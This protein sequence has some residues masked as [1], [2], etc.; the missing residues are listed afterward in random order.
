MTDSRKPLRA[1]LYLRL[2]VT[3]DE[4]TSI[5]R[6]EK[7]LRDLAD[8]EGWEVVQV[9]T[10]D[11][12]SGGK[13]RAK[14]DRALEMLRDGHADVIAVWKFDRWS[15]QGVRAVAD[16]VETIDGREASGRPALFVAMGDGIRSDAQTWRMHV[17]LIAEVGRMERENV[18]TRVA[19]ARAHL[20]QQRKHSGRVPYGYRTCPH[21]SGQGRG[22]EIDPHESK[23]VRRAVDMVLAGHSPYLTAK[24]LNEEGLTPRT[25]PL[26]NASLLADMLRRDSLL[27][28]MT[29]RIR[30]D[31]TRTYRPL[32]DENGLPEQ[33]WPP[34]I[35]PDEAR[36]LRAGISANSKWGV[37]TRAGIK[38]G[39][40]LLSG[41][42]V[43]ATCG[44]SMRA[45]QGD[46]LA[47][48]SVTNRYVCGAAPGAC[49][50]K[51]S[52]TAH[53]IEDHVV[54]EF[55]ALAGHFQVIEY[56]E[57]SRDTGELAEV[58]HAITETAAQMTAP[59]ANI[60]AL[61]DRLTK[62]RARRE[63]LE[64]VP[65]EPVVEQVE[66]GQTFA[67]AWEAR[68]LPGRRALLAGALTGS[69]V[70]K[71]AIRGSKKMDVRRLEIPWRWVDIDVDYEL[72]D[73]A[74]AD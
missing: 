7:D 20:R 14:A 19:S 59:D 34:L 44:G 62:L 69:I 9:L 74:R 39:K 50:A 16:L 26:W 60:V 55:L 72:A 53:L 12:L 66:T 54:A 56:R 6:Q 67:E 18:A 15:R 43:C 11:G 13:R 4:S 47:D 48:G 21:P 70:V 51:V 42:L 68:E 27:G 61:V 52:V 29:H 22:L 17:S 35:T 25:A 71:P 73:A 1:V 38:R 5:V 10:D 24:K 63:F 64:T 2:S 49:K 40:R 37:V 46:T 41:L 57:T 3:T 65:A 58:E 8:R 23:I 36:A 31:N 30:G 32:L 45:G 28:Y 33:V